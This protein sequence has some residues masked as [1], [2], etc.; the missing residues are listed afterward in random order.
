MLTFAQKY[1]YD[2]KNM[3]IMVAVPLFGGIMLQQ[4]GI[5]KKQRQQ[6]NGRRKILL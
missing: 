1:N 4:E 5:A 3:S 2:K 6:P